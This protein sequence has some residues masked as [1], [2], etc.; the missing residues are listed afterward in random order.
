[1]FGL[2]G[3]ALVSVNKYGLERKFC[4]GIHNTTEKAKVAASDKAR[5]EAGRKVE[6]DLRDS[7]KP[8]K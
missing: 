8:V 1:M 2:T 5:V 3:T 7:E 6:K 4:T